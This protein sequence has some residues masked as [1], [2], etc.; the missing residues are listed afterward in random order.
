VL[1]IEAVAHNTQELNCGRSLDKFPEVVSRL[2]AILERFAD[3]LS[4]IDPC[5]IAEERRS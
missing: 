5:F 1:R 2:K 3:A 4:C